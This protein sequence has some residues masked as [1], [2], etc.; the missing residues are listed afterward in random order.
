MQRTVIA[1]QGEVHH[2]PRQPR[3]Q[4]R[5]TA[6]PHLPR[7]QT[8]LSAQSLIASGIKSCGDRRG[9]HQLRQVI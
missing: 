8:D 2:P 1:Q 3:S 4:P 7:D 5:Q 6:Q 9:Q